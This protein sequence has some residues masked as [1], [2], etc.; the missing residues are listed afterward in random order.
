LQKKNVLQDMFK[1]A[2]EALSNDICTNLHNFQK[3]NLKKS[4]SKVLFHFVYIL[5][6]KL[7]TDGVLD[8]SFFYHSITAK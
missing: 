2:T 4:G 7:F 6:A 8:I 5:E 3:R 1:Y